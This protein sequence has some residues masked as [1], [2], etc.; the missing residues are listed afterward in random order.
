MNTMMPVLKYDK[1][2]IKI[3]QSDNLELLKQTKTE[4]INLIYCDILYNSGKKFD[5]YDDDLG[6]PA[7][8]IEWY[9]PRIE[10][11]HRVLSK[12]GSI[13]IH[14]NWRID[15][16]IRALLDEIFGFYHFRNRIYR[17]HSKIRYF[18]GNLDSQVDTILYYVK[19]TNNFTFNEIYGDELHT[20]P[21]FENGT[22]KVRSFDFT[23]KDFSF[24]P[25]KHGKHWLIPSQKLQEL[26]NKGELVLIDGYPY[27]KTYA[28]PIGNLWDEEEMLDDYSRTDVAE[29]Y[30]TPKPPLVLSRI[31]TMFSNPG[32]T[33]ADFFLGGGRTAMEVVASGRKGVFCDISGKAVSVSMK[34]VE[35]TVMEIKNGDK[36]NG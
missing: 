22:D 28:V 17:K 7:E 23:Y 27:R 1:N 5:D 19:D 33:V 26:Y 9:R 20:V 12:N 16:Y 13:F 35:K 2:D 3:Y 24:N 36:K 8:A 32:D 15:S 4:S 6:T 31:I 21:L 29:S 34:N 11:M 18:V 30:D 14:C 25:L 10:E